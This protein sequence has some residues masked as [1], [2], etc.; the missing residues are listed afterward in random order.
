MY[1][2]VGIALDKMNAFVLQRSA[3]IRECFL[4]QLWQKKQTGSLVK[5]L[6]ILSVSSSNLPSGAT[7]VAVAVDQT[8]PPTREVVLLN[9]RDF[10]PGLGEARRGCN[11]ACTCTNNNHARARIELLFSHAEVV[12]MAIL[13]PGTT[14]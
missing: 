3:E 8:T 1:I 13:G 6:W 2:I 7:Y 4:E 5:S 10:A 9:K 12:E 11:T 14:A